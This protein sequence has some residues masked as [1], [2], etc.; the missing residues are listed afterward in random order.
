MATR[1]Q[2]AEFYDVPLET[3]KT[4]VK[5]NKEELNEDG[6]SVLLGRDVVDSLKSKN[7]LK[8]IQTK[9]GKYTVT[10]SSGEELS[11]ANRHN[12]I[13]TKRAILRVG[14]LL[15]GSEIAKEVR[16]Q[17][18][19]IEEH[20][21]TEVKTYE[22]DYEQDLH[23]KL[24]QAIAKQWKKEVKNIRLNGG[25]VQRDRPQLYTAAVEHFVF[26]EMAVSQVS[27]VKY[28][29]K[30]LAEQDREHNRCLLR[31]H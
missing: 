21:S 4:V 11:V 2:V 3:I 24:G 26:V 15:K 13:F 27:A 5:D 30:S 9:P 23:L 14:L 17:L 16:T 18:L 25:Y 8:E 19:N 22:I 1:E 29:T 10:F 6:Y 20:T 31:L 7:N 12:A 28:K